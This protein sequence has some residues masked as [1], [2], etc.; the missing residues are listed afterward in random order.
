MADRCASRGLIEAAL[1][2]QL[3][4]R[5]ARQLAREDPE[6][7]ALALLAASKHIAEQAK[8]IAELQG[9]SDAQELSPST[10]SGMVPVYTKPNAPKRSRQP[11]AKNGHPGR[12]RETP[13]RI[14]RRQE[15]RLKRCPAAAVR[16]SGASENAPG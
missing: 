7:L 6:V 11:G 5:Q 4:Q 14:D 8:V 12:R 2:G 10:P 1:R 16:F 15:H 13:T 9:Q 3:S